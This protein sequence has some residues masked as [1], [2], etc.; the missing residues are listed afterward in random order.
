MGVKRWRT[1]SLDRIELTSIM[2]ESKAK[3]KRA[4]VLKNKNKNKLLPLPCVS[5]RSA[6]W[7]LSLTVRAEITDVKYGFPKK[8]IR[9]LSDKHEVQLRFITL[10]A[11]HSQFLWSHRYCDQTERKCSPCEW[12]LGGSPFELPQ[13]AATSVYSHAVAIKHLVFCTKNVFVCC[14]GAHD[15]QLLYR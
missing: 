2:R 9:L 10:R 3:L 5:S 7:Q 11:T 15:K 12:R 13:N 6:Q 1:G 4:L 8:T 14:Y